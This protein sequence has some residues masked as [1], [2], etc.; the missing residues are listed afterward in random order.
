MLRKKKIGAIPIKDYRQC[1]KNKASSVDSKLKETLQVQG[2][3]G[4]Y[5]CK[6]PKDYF[7]TSTDTKVIAHGVGGCYGNKFQVNDAMTHTVECPLQVSAV[8]PDP[9]E[10]VDESW[11]ACVK[12]GMQ[13]ARV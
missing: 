12:R 3:P 4:P 8:D 2:V 13:A 9:I 7:I 5:Q 6:S 1:L 10:V 11:D